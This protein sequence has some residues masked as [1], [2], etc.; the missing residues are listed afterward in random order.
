MG[1]TASASAPSSVSSL[2]Q[3]VRAELVRTAYDD[4]IY[5]ASFA[6]VIV[7]IVSATMLTAF[8]ARV[9]YPWTAA[10]LTCNALRLLSRWAYRR[11]RRHRIGRGLGH[12]ALLWRERSDLPRDCRVRA[13][14]PDDRR[15]AAVR[16]NFLGQPRL[17][18]SLG[19]AAP[20]AV[21]RRSEEH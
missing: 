21:S 9:V 19:P 15:V 5:G 6:A 8:P 20:V 13:R 10:M 2:D 18:L 16:A 11:Q 1:S 17:P 3:R 4:A 14:G 12:V 7:L